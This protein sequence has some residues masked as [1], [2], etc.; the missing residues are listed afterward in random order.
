L[1]VLFGL[2]KDSHIDRR[3]NFTFREERNER[4]IR[5]ERGRNRRRNESDWR[6]NRIL[7]QTNASAHAWSGRRLTQG[8]AELSAAN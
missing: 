3:A 8:W 7:Y 5:K 1:A 2:E 6:K 4:T